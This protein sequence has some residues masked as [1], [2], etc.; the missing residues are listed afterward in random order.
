[1]KHNTPLFYGLGLPILHG[2]IHFN[3]GL[4][5]IAKKLSSQLPV[6]ISST[7]RGTTMWKQYQ[8]HFIMLIRNPHSGY[9]M[10][11]GKNSDVLLQIM[12]KWNSRP[13]DATLLIINSVCR[14]HHSFRQLL[15]DTKQLPEYENVLYS[16]TRKFSIEMTRLQSWILL[17]I[18]ITRFST[19]KH[20]A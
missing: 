9:K 13:E 17:I 19:W 5:G 20:F 16:V 18:T 1:M 2:P 8:W 15:I 12:T 3:S 14:V 11:F 4:L 10:C 6:I 7:H